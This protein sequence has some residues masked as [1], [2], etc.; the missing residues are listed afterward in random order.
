MGLDIAQ[1]VDELG[2]E[3]NAYTDPDSLVLYGA[4][5]QSAAG[6][7][8]SFLAALIIDAQFTDT[9]VELEKEIVRQELLDLEDSS[10][11]RRPIRVFAAHSGPNLSLGCLLLAQA[12]RSDELRQ[13]ICEIDSVIQIRFE[14][15][16]CGGCTE[17]FR[18]IQSRV[19]NIW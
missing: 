14:A 11:R 18:D 7:L 15:R 12:I 13:M 4:V 2:G 9:D 6:E 5:P 3:V 16:D 19:K 10:S 1:K 17:G 8:L